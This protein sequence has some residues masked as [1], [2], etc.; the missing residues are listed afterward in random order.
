MEIYFSGTQKLIITETYSM[1]LIGSDTLVWN[2]TISKLY[3]IMTILT[4][5]ELEVIGLLY[6]NLIKTAGKL[7]NKK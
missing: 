1:Y 4:E 6:V 3:V 2:V 5:S 7:C